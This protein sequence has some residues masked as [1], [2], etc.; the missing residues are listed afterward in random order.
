VSCSIVPSSVSNPGKR[1]IGVVA[2]TRFGNASVELE[3]TRVPSAFAKPRTWLT[4][5]RSGPHKPIPRL[6]QDPAPLDLCTA[7]NDRLQQRRIKSPEPC[8]QL[9]IDAV[10][11]R[12]VLRDEPHPPRVRHNR[13]VPLIRDT[14]TVSAFPPRAPPGSS[15]TRPSVNRSPRSRPIVSPLPTMIRLLT[16]AS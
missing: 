16:S 9:C 13:L 2:R 11:L 7:V 12:V 5:L 6:D 15:R 3:G 1:S 14:P 8:Q 4:R 10:G